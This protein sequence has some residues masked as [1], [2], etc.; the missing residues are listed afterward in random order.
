[1]IKANETTFEECIKTL[2]KFNYRPIC[3]QT[4]E[5]FDEKGKLHEQDNEHEIEDMGH[6]INN[7]MERKALL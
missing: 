7:G 1:M 6:E 3:R 5:L 4:I 2:S